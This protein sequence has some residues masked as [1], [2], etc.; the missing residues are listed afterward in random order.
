MKVRMKV[1][2]SG[3]RGGTEWPGP[4]EVL[5]VDDQEGMALCQGGLAEPVADLDA[6][7]ATP[8][9]AEK[10]TARRPAKKATN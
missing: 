6:E 8:A 3:T 2:I 4:G 5:E 1:G 10:R 7:T 9:E